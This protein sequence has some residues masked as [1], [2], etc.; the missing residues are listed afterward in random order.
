MVGPAPLRTHLRLLRV[1]PAL[2]EGVREGT[3]SAR[4]IDRF[5]RGVRHGL[6]RL[7]PLF[8]TR[9]R[10]FVC[11]ESPPIMRNL[12]GSVLRTTKRVAATTRF[13]P[14]VVKSAVLSLPIIAG[15]HFEEYHHR[16]RSTSDPAPG[17]GH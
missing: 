9:D 15:E 4:V 16:R 2:H 12:V 11:E 14:P 5:V 3:G 7:I 6:R 13:A 1:A 8:E 10:P 17:E